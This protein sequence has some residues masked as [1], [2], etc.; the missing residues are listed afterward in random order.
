MNGMLTQLPQVDLVE[1]ASMFS[2]TSVKHFKPI[3]LMPMVELV[4]DIT[5]EE[6]VDE[7]VLQ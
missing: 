6:L 3:S 7:D 2:I 1:V 5:Q 4:M